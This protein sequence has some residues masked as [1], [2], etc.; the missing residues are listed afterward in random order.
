MFI[1]L[2]LVIGVQSDYVIDS[3][4]DNVYW[5]GGSIVVTPDD[6]IVN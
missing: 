2:V 3:P 6:D 5:C 1:L 4:V